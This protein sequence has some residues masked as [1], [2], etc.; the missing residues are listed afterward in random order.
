MN[1][2]DLKQAYKQE[3]DAYVKIK[4]SAM[5]CSYTRNKSIQDTADTFNPQTGVHKWKEHFDN[6]K[7]FQAFVL[8][9]EQVGHHISPTGVV[10]IFGKKVAK[11]L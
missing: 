10:H 8:A 6:G 3:K 7:A 9:L 5:L 2:I 4:I 1:T 11:R